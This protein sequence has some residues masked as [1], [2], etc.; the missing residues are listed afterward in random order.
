[1]SLQSKYIGFLDAIKLTRQSDE[2]KTVR[3]KDD[4][5]TGKVEAAFKKEGYT[6][7]RNFIQGSLAQFVDIG[8][9]PLDGDYDIDRAIAIE[10][11]NNAPED[12][13]EPKKIVRDV[14]DAHGFKEPRIKRPCVTADYKGQ[15][16]HIDFPVYK[17][18]AFDDYFIAMG[19]ENSSDESKGWEE[20]DP[21]GLVDWIKKR[22]TLVETLTDEEHTQFRRVARY[23][24]RWRDHTYTNDTERKKIYSIGLTVMFK[25]V[26]SPE[27]SDEGKADDHKALINTVEEIIDSAY[28]FT[29]LGEGKY[30]LQVDLPVKPNEDI[31]TKHGKTVG[32]S[33]RNK[34]KKLLSDL[35]EVSEME[36]ISDQ[37][38]KLRK[39]FGDD[40]P[41]DN[42]DPDGERHKAKEAG[43]VG[44]S[45]GA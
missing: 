10:D 27:I 32:T 42:S 43:V 5:V 2:Y 28:F 44:V 18:D 13:V 14:L 4:L 1:M 45:S 7:K 20:A 36:S 26:F 25:T 8:V 22:E 11:D 17:V 31:F 3:E 34:L 19:N 9:K 23:I 39:V 33:F 37:C 38:E 40:F 15:N 41:E 16:F 24:K 29:D 6:V 12:P 21:K 35:K 30:D